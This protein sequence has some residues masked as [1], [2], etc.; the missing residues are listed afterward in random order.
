M[1]NSGALEGGECAVAG[2]GGGGVEGRHSADGGDATGRASRAKEAASVDGDKATTHT[3]D[4]VT[5]NKTQTLMSSSAPAT[6]LSTSPALKQDDT[7]GGS[8]GGSS[9]VVK[10]ST[11]RKL[12]CLYCERSFVSATLRQKHVERVHSV[13]QSRRISSRRQSQLTVTPCVYCDH[14]QPDNT[15]DDLFR[16]LVQEHSNR[17]FG[18]LT[19]KDRFL[20][21]SMLA[22][23]NA[24]IHP[25]SDSP[26]SQPDSQKVQTTTVQE[27]S[28]GSEDP[29]EDPETD[30]EVTVKVTRSRIKKSEENGKK[31]GKLRDLRSR[32]LTVK[33]SRLAL[34]KKEGK[35]MSLKIAETQQRKRSK[36]LDRATSGLKVE[37]NSSTK[38]TDKQTKSGS[39][40]VNPYPEFDSFYR[41]K[42]ITDHSIDN[43]KISSLTFDDVFDKAFFNRIKCNI[44]ENLLH[45]IDGKLFKNQESE[46][47]ISNFEKVSTTP[48]ESQSS[49]QENYGCELSL[50]AVTPVASLSLNSQFGEDFESQI[51]YGAKPSKK[52]TQSK[53]D[54]VHYKYFTRRKFQA[55]ILEQK[56]N[57]DLSKLDMWT[58][59]V[60]K[61][62]QQK[63]VDDK[64]SA[65]EMLE[66]SSCDEYKNK[67]RKEELNKIL[68]RRGPFED[69]KEEASKKA[70][71]DKLNSLNPDRRISP[72][73]FLEVREVLN[74]ILNKVFTLTE[75]DSESEKI[76]EN[77]NKCE[78]VREIPGYLNLRPSSSLPTE[79]DIDHSDK[80]T[81]ICSS[82]E[83]DN[84]EL[85]SN[86][87]RLKDELVELSGE[88][89]RCRMYVCAACGAKLPNMRYLL[90]HKNIYHQNVWVQHY[91]FVGNQSE[92]YRHLSIPAL[93]KVGA[94][95]ERIPCKLWKR[96]DARLCTKCDRQCNSLG[97]L[98]RHVLEC[99]GDWTWMLVRK[100][101]KYKPFGTKSRRKRRGLVQRHRQ[102]T[103]PTERKKYKK[104]FEGPRQKPSDAETIQRMLANLPAKRST[105]KL[106]SFQEGVYKSR[107]NAAASKI[108]LKTINQKKIKCG[109]VIYTTRSIKENM[110]KTVNTQ[111]KPSTSSKT[112][113]SLNKVLS[114]R[115]LDTNAKFSVKR[116]LQALKKQ[117]SARTATATSTER[118]ESSESS[119]LTRSS[120]RSSSKESKQVA[121]TVKKI[122]SSKLNIK[123][124]FPVKK[125]N[126]GKGL[127]ENVSGTDA[128]KKPRGKKT[129]G[130]KS[131]SENK[132]TKTETAKSTAKALDA[133][134]NQS[135]LK[136]TEAKLK[137]LKKPAKPTL[138]NDEADKTA[139]KRK[140]KQ[141]LKNVLNK[142]KKLK[143]DGAASDQNKAQQPNVKD[144][145]LDEGK[146][147]KLQLPDRIVIP[148]TLETKENIADISKNAPV[149][150][151]FNESNENPPIPETMFK[152]QSDNE[153]NLQAKGELNFDRRNVTLETPKT[154]PEMPVEE[155]TVPAEEMKPI[156]IDTTTKSKVTPL[157]S[158]SAKPKTWKPA[159][160]LNDCIAM[161]TSKLQQHTDPK[162]VEPSSVLP[163]VI[164]VFSSSTS[165][166]VLEDPIPHKTE[167][168]LK[169]PTFKTN[170]PFGMEET[171]LD[172]STKKKSEE[173]PSPIWPVSIEQIKLNTV[174]S[175]VDKTIEDVIN[176][177]GLHLS[178]DFGH[179]PSKVQIQFP[180]SSVDDIIDFVVANST[181]ENFKPLEGGI[182]KIR[183]PRKPRDR[184]S[185]SKKTV[186]ICDILK[187]DE[188]DLVVT[189]GIEV[190]EVE[191]VDEVKVGDSIVEDLENILK[192][193]VVTVTSDIL[194]ATTGT[195]GKPDK[196]KEDYINVS[197]SDIMAPAKTKIDTV[198]ENNVVPQAVRFKEISED[199]KLSN[200]AEINLQG[201]KQ[202]VEKIEVKKR[203]RK[204]GQVRKPPVKK[205]EK[206][207]ST[208]CPKKPVKKKVDSITNISIIEEKPEVIETRCEPKK[209][210]VLET[211][212][213]NLLDINEIKN[214]IEV[215]TVQVDPNVNS[216]LKS[217]KIQLHN[218]D[219]P[220]LL[221]NK[222]VT[223]IGKSTSDS[224]DDVPLIALKTVSRSTS[225]ENLT[226][227][228]DKSADSRTDGFE[229]K[230]PPN[231]LADLQKDDVATTEA[232]ESVSSKA[233]DT[234]T[235]IA[236]EKLVNISRSEASDLPEVTAA[237]QCDDKEGKVEPSLSVSKPP[238]E[239][240]SKKLKKAPKGQLR[241]KK[242]LSRSVTNLTT[243]FV[244]SST[245]QIEESEEMAKDDS[246]G[247]LGKQIGE[248]IAVQKQIKRKPL[249]KDQG[250][251]AATTKEATLIVDTVV[252]KEDP[253]KEKVV[254]R[255]VLIKE[256]KL[257]AALSKHKEKTAMELQNF[258]TV[259]P[260]NDQFLSKSKSEPCLFGTLKISPLLDNF[261]PT[262]VHIKSK[263]PEKQSKEDKKLD[264]IDSSE[265][266]LKGD[267]KLIEITENTVGGTILGQNDALKETAKSPGITAIDSVLDETKIAIE[268]SP[269]AGSTTKASK[270]RGKIGNLMRGIKNRISKVVSR[271]KSTNTKQKTLL[272]KDEK[273]DSKEDVGNFLVTDSGALP[274]STNDLNQTPSDGETIKELLDT[275]STEVDDKPKPVRRRIPRS[276]FSMPSEKNS[277]I[278]KSTTDGHDL[279]KIDSSADEFITPLEPA[280]RRSRRPKTPSSTITTERSET[281]LPDSSVAD[282]SKADV[283][284][285]VSG[286]SRDHEEIETLGND[287]R[288]DTI[289]VSDTYK[290]S[291]VILDVK[292][293]STN[294][295]VEKA[296][297]PF[298]APLEPTRRIS[299]NR[300]SKSDASIRSLNTSDVGSS[301]KDDHNAKHLEDIAKP[302]EV[303]QTKLTIKSKL[304]E[305]TILASDLGISGSDA[306]KI[307]DKL[308]FVDP[309]ASVLAKIRKRGSQ[310]KYSNIEGSDADIDSS[311]SD[312]DESI[313]VSNNM[314]IA[315]QDG[316]LAD[317]QPL[318][319]TTELLQ[320]RFPR[321]NSR[322]TKTLKSPKSAA[323]A[324]P[325]VT[326]HL[327]DSPPRKYNDQIADEAA[328]KVPKLK[329]TRLPHLT[330]APVV[331]KDDDKIAA[332]CNVSKRIARKTRILETSEIA[333]ST[334]DSEL[335]STSDT[336][337][338][339]FTDP[340]GPLHNTTP[341]RMARNKRSLKKTYSESNISD[342]CESLD[343]ACITTKD[344]ENIVNEHDDSIKSSQVR[345]PKRSSRRSKLSTAS[346]VDSK[347]SESCES[348][349]DAGD[350]SKTT[351]DDIL[352]SSDSCVSPSQMKL[353]KKSSR[354]TKLSKTSDVESNVSDEFLND[355][356]DVSK[357]TKDDDNISD[358]SIKPLE[359]TLAKRSSRKSE[360]LNTFDIESNIS[361]NCEPSNKDVD[362]NKQDDAISDNVQTSDAS[363]Q[364]PLI[365][366]RKRNIRKSKKMSD[367]KLDLFD[368]IHEDRDIDTTDESNKKT[369]E[370]AIDIQQKAVTKMD[371]RKLRVS[372]TS[373]L[374]PNLPDPVTP[375]SIENHKCEEPLIVRISKIDVEANKATYQADEKN[376]EDHE[377]Y[378]SNSI[379]RGFRPEN[380]NNSN[381]SETIKE[382]FALPL[383]PVQVKVSRR[384]GKIARR[385]K[386]SKIKTPNEAEVIT[387][388]TVSDN[389]DSFS[390]ASEL[391][392]NQSD[393]ESSEEQIFINTVPIQSLKSVSTRTSNSE[394]ATKELNS[395]VCNN[396]VSPDLNESDENS[397]I[398]QAAKTSLKKRGS[399]QSRRSMSLKT[400]GESSAEDPAVNL[401]NDLM[402]NLNYPLIRGKATEPSG[403]DLDTYANTSG[404]I[405]NDMLDVE[406]DLISLKVS[407]KKG[408]KRTSKARMTD[409]SS[410]T[411]KIDVILNPDN[412]GRG[413]DKQDGVNASNLEKEPSPLTPNSEPIQRT[414]PKRRA[415]ALK[416]NKTEIV[417]AISYSDDTEKVNKN[418][419]ADISLNELE[420]NSAVTEISSDTSESFNFNDS[421]VESVRRKLPQRRAKELAPAQVSNASQLS[422]NDELGTDTANTDPNTS[423]TDKSV[424]DTSFNS[425]SSPDEAT[426]ITPT[427][428][429]KRTKISEEEIDTKNLNIVDEQAGLQNNEFQS[430]RETRR[431][432]SSKS[433][434]SLS[435]T[436]LDYNTHFE[437]SASEGCESVDENDKM[438]DTID[439]AVDSDDFLKQGGEAVFDVTGTGSNASE[440]SV[441][442]IRNSEAAVVQRT[443]EQPLKRKS[444][445]SSSRS[446]VSE[447][448]DHSTKSGQKHVPTEDTI[449]VDKTNQRPSEETFVTTENFET[450]KKDSGTSRKSNILSRDL[451]SDNAET[452]AIDSADS[453]KDE[454]IESARP[455]PGEIP[456]VAPVHPVKKSS[457]RGDRVAR[458]VGGKQNLVDSSASED[459]ESAD[460]ISMK[461]EELLTK[462]RSKRT[463]EQAAKNVSMKISESESSEDSRDMFNRN[464]MSDSANS[465]DNCETGESISISESLLRSNSESELFLS[466]FLDQR[467]T[468]KMKKFINGNSITTGE[469][470]DKKEE[471]V[472][473]VKLKK[474]KSCVTAKEDNETVSHSLESSPLEQETP[475]EKAIKGKC[476]GLTEK[477]DTSNFADMIDA[478]NQKHL[479]PSQEEY[480]LAT[481]EVNE[482]E[483]SLLDL[484]I[485]EKDNDLINPSVVLH[486]L[487]EDKLDQLQNSCDTDE[488]AKRVK[489]SDAVEKN[490]VLPR[491][492]GRAK[493]SNKAQGAGISLIIKN[494]EMTDSDNAS[495]KNDINLAHNNLDEVFDQLKVGNDKISQNETS[496]VQ[497]E[498]SEVGST[499]RKNSGLQNDTNEVTEDT[500]TSNL[501][502]TSLGS[503]DSSSKDT[504]EPAMTTSDVLQDDSPSKK[505]LTEKQ[506]EKLNPKPGSNRLRS[507]SAPVK[508]S[509]KSNES[510]FR[511]KSPKKRQ[512]HV[513]EQPIED[514]VTD[515]SGIEKSIDNSITEFDDDIF[516]RPR[517]LRKKPQISYVEP[518][519]MN[520]PRREDSD[521]TSIFDMYDMKRFV[522]ISSDASTKKQVADRKKSLPG[523]KPDFYTNVMTN[524]VAVVFK[525]SEQLDIE[526]LEKYTQPNLKKKSENGEST[527]DVLE[528]TDE[529]SKTSNPLNTSSDYARQDENLPEKELVDFRENQKITKTPT[530]ESIRIII[531]K[532]KTRRKSKSFKKTDLKG[533]NDLFEDFA[534]VI[535]KPKKGVTPIIRFSPADTFLKDTDV[536]D[537]KLPEVETEQSSFDPNNQNL[538]SLDESNQNQTEDAS[539]EE[540]DMELDEIPISSNI[541]ETEK[542][543]D[544]LQ[545][546]GISNGTK[547]MPKK[548]TKGKRSTRSKQKSNTGE[549]FDGGNKINVLENIDDIFFDTGKEIAEMEEPAVFNFETEQI[550]GTDPDGL[551]RL[552]TRTRSNK[553]IDAIVDS[554]I[555]TV[556]TTTDVCNKSEDIDRK[557]G[558]GKANV[559]E[560]VVPLS[561]RSVIDEKL[562]V[563][564]KELDSTIDAVLQ[565]TNVFGNEFENAL[566]ALDKIVPDVPQTD[567]T[568]F[569]S[570]KSNRICGKPIINA[571]DDT[572]LIE[573]EVSEQNN[574]RSNSR[575]R[576]SKKLEE[577]SGIPVTTN[578]LNSNVNET[579][580]DDKEPRRANSSEYENMVDIFENELM[581]GI[582]IEQQREKPKTRSK[583]CSKKSDKEMEATIHN[584]LEATSVFDNELGTLMQDIENQIIPELK[585]ATK[586]DSLT[587]GTLQQRKQKAKGR[588]CTKKSLK[589]TDF[590]LKST[591]DDK[592]ETAPEINPEDADS[593]DDLDDEFIDVMKSESTVSK[594]Q[595]TKELS[596]EVD[597][598]AEDIFKVS[599][600]TK[601]LGSDCVIEAGNDKPELNEKVD[602][603]SSNISDIQT[604]E[605]TAANETV[606]LRANSSLCSTNVSLEVNNIGK[607]TSKGRSRRINKKCEKI[608]EALNTTVKEFI[609]PKAKPKG[610]N[611]ISSTVPTTDLI[612]DVPSEPGNEKIKDIDS[613]YAFNESE[614]FEI[615]KPIELPLRLPRKCNLA[616]VVTENSNI[617]EQNNQK[618]VKEDKGMSNEYKNAY[619]EEIQPIEDVVS[620]EEK[621][622]RAIKLSLLE[623]SA[624]EEAEKINS[625]NEKLELMESTVRNGKIF[626]EEKICEDPEADD[627]STKT[628][629]LAN[630][631]AKE[632]VVQYNTSHVSD[633]A[634]DSILYNI[635]TNKSCSEVEEVRTGNRKTNKRGKKIGSSVQASCIED[636]PLVDLPADDSLKNLDEQLI[637]RDESIFR[638]IDGQNKVD[639]LT[640]RQDSNSIERRSESVQQDFL[641]VNERSYLEGSLVDDISINNI[642]DDFLNKIDTNEDILNEICNEI[643]N[644]ETNNMKTQEISRDTREDIF[645]K[646]DANTD[647]FDIV[648]NYI[649]ESL[650][651]TTK[652]RKIARK[653]R[654]RAKMAENNK[655]KKSVNTGSSIDDVNISGEIKNS[656]S[657]KQSTNMT[658]KDDKKDGS[659]MQ[660]HAQTETNAKEHVIKDDKCSEIASSTL[661][662]DPLEKKDFVNIDNSQAHVFNTNINEEL[663]V[664]QQ[665]LADKG[666]KDVVGDI[667]DT[668]DREK[669]ILE[670]IDREIEENKASKAKKK[671]K[672]STITL[673]ELSYSNLAQL[674]DQHVDTEKIDDVLNQSDKELSENKITDVKSKRVV[675]RKGRKSALSPDETAETNDIDLVI[676]QLNQQ[677]PLE[678]SLDEKELPIT[679][680]TLLEQEIVE[681]EPVEKKVPTKKRLHSEIVGLIEPEIEPVEEGVRKRAVR[682][683]KVKALEHIHDDAL[684]ELTE[685]ERNKQI[686]RKK[687]DEDSTAPV[688]NTKKQTKTK[689]MPVIDPMDFPK[690]ILQEKAPLLA[691]LVADL[692]GLEELRNSI[693]RELSAEN[694]LEGTEEPKQLEEEI[695]ELRRSRRSSR[696]IASYNENEFDPILDALENK[697]NAKKK[698]IVAKENKISNEKDVAKKMNSDELFNLLKASTTEEMYV[699]KPQNSFL[700]N[701]EDTSRDFNDQNFDNVFDNLLEKST[702]LIK[703]S[704]D[705]NIEK[706]DADKIYEFTD[707]P[708]TE[709][710]SISGDCSSKKTKRALQCITPSIKITTDENESMSSELT[711]E[712]KSKAKGNEKNSENYC[713]I[714]N[715]SFVRVESLVKHKRTLTHIQK[716]SEIEAREASEKLKS[717][718][719]QQDTEIN[720]AGEASNVRGD[721]KDKDLERIE[722]PI[723]PVTSSYSDSLK[724]DSSNSNALQTPIIEQNK[725]FVDIIMKSSAEV[726]PKYK[727]YKSLGERKS[728]ESDN[729]VPSDSITE[730]YLIS[731]T[732]IL[733]K[734]ISLLENI[735][736]NQTGGV[737]YAD[738]MSLS[739]NNS[740]RRVTSS[741]DTTKIVDESQTEP[742]K[743]GDDTFLKPAQYEEISEDSANLRSYEEQKLRKTLNRDEELF[744]ECCSLLKSG[745]EVSKSRHVNKQQYAWSKDKGVP[746]KPPF[747]EADESSNGNSRIATPLGSSY[748]DDASGS[749]TISSNWEMRQETAV[750]LERDG[751][752]TR[753]FGFQI[754]EEEREPLNRANEI[755]KPLEVT[756]SENTKPDESIDVK[757]IMTKGARKVFE[758]LKVSIPT[759][760]LN[761]EEVLNTG[762]KSKKG[763]EVE[764]MEESPKKASRKSKPVKKSQ[765]GSNMMFKVNKKKGSPNTNIVIQ[766]E[767]PET[768]YDVYDFEETQDNTEVFTKPD[769]KA[770]KNVKTTDSQETIGEPTEQES[771]TDSRDYL[772]TF[773]VER[774]SSVSSLASSVVKKPKAQENITKK[775]C[776]IMG[777][778]FKNAA[779][780]KVEDIDEDIR[781]IPPIDNDELIENYVASCKRVIRN[782]SKPK[783]S[784]SEINLLF[785][786]LLEDKIEIKEGEEQAEM[787]TAS[788]PAA[789]VAAPPK[790]KQESKEV[791]KKTESKKKHPKI[792]GKKRA[793][794]HSDSTDDEFKITN[795]AKRS[796]KKATKEE[797]NC[798]NLELELKECIGVASRKSQRKCTSGKQNVLVEYWSSD[799]SQ[800][801]AMLESQ[802]IISKTTTD[803]ELAQTVP[804]SH[805]KPVEDKPESI[806]E[807][808]PEEK[809][810][811]EKKVQ[812]KKTV[813][814][815]K[816]KQRPKDATPGDGTMTSDDPLGASAAQ[817]NRRKRAATNPLYHWSSSSEDESQDLIEVKPIRDEPED[818]EDRPIQH[819]WIVGDSPKKLVTMLAQAKGKKTDAD[820]VKEQGKKRTANSAVS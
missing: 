453:R 353:L 102:K 677:K 534:L 469:L 761:M 287:G 512:K 742:K 98:H 495:M 152:L 391:S 438:I 242:A 592:A 633:L 480:C 386:V 61:K 520:T 328:E 539:V 626:N 186:N 464:Y 198:V 621:I 753:N 622:R 420:Q 247:L 168:I 316:S 289:L 51:E 389:S 757:K 348:A 738:D 562:E 396:N 194:P 599:F 549:I 216:S 291:V 79:G 249:K 284:L 584:V 797:D 301:I 174:R 335:Y 618:V 336:N 254:K 195:E 697:N 380:Q 802:K 662:A 460:D 23:H 746:H 359:T 637:S 496:A 210:P 577:V 473:K 234:S 388:S 113:R 717:C 83:T 765:V 5:V 361:D 72:E 32:R 815:K 781:A 707:S 640:G 701:L 777:R 459:N 144:P 181:N 814:G 482:S 702:L 263:S 785:D 122:L 685:S 624:P 153:K 408:L 766:S 395:S 446:K 191:K 47:R 371:G 150:I 812:S 322:K 151:N 398:L 390:D 734:Q 283:N 231:E 415:K 53:K 532:Q 755:F 288:G 76:N 602:I 334:S 209:A 559:A 770:F 628:K 189:K 114:S 213:D 378:K 192:Q 642:D 78:D 11:V 40:C 528:K 544:S 90:D 9:M 281:D 314:N 726:E 134:P 7:S 575:S 698:E 720:D 793:R 763:D 589:R 669:V 132:K 108:P 65:K 303:I 792:K 435:D 800:F 806:V 468:R 256:S 305:Q 590:D 381:S 155:A 514:A 619:A 732:S 409:N 472:E 600:E 479:N 228:T 554:D 778:I 760:E 258:V 354:K 603:T 729:S 796:Y 727:R 440:D 710:L 260:K 2:G 616:P 97:E 367:G 208:K 489:T 462:R 6:P 180:R 759:E 319:S 426:F 449:T 12:L 156:S 529:I 690:D 632:T 19:C 505:K 706:K 35:K 791:N 502:A 226:K 719:S 162:P 173:I 95:E 304:T 100:K 775:K 196:K 310:P 179:H 692:A 751:G 119:R 499:S 644:N 486:Q 533:P 230:L 164:S 14:Q 170:I 306:S 214:N 691:D 270:K 416:T 236:A 111:K 411:E 730:P 202:L 807:K 148:S 392:V 503:G 165:T 320:V 703:A 86:P 16:H 704:A 403:K 421:E 611:K 689:L 394:K 506:S 1:V 451:P 574:L 758:G 492:K 125:Q 265:V 448:P 418:L 794:T 200:D 203:V 713:E 372:K 524:N 540:M 718:E 341:I 443:E 711:A 565:A 109:K 277:D 694:D 545:I 27:E 654:T 430:R 578:E 30:D 44:E 8:S 393:I 124:F 178:W 526:S 75:Q 452:V 780:S 71:L 772:D 782:E 454:I 709:S 530:E 325:D 428:R 120:P 484:D 345:T 635:D 564:E 488:I 498:E 81:L 239:V 204:I 579:K 573:N 233:N 243:E 537:I 185:G 680:G 379:N 49:S 138:N 232:K 387:H 617:V 128:D 70:A 606:S 197:K 282:I 25:S 740:E 425:N 136:K 402:E 385:G 89:A 424:D 743:T 510:R 799:E 515:D 373:V 171:A 246:D 259:P 169:I 516:E 607:Q 73:S 450:P 290:N 94:V 659:I 311:I 658:R 470:Q 497:N 673:P 410:T 563:V 349:I 736:E 546:D 522:S 17:Y 733:E 149:A 297:D 42:K 296:D 466:D 699:P 337:S 3:K 613:I 432:M 183:S 431:S 172:L 427:R 413:N 483:R 803:T 414:T 455:T 279:D 481:K 261:T 245:K 68:D 784:E 553:N 572:N 58:Q 773:T 363:N 774:D 59:L 614:D 326:E 674:K 747:E 60:I 182:K 227:D 605:H 490:K 400:L 56:E 82:R 302:A 351:K 4:T 485:L 657:T 819:G 456:F 276:K 244:E 728:F 591:V 555:H 37:P 368:G 66:Y 776:M 500:N 525:S 527:T 145:F 550:A 580:S 487:I 817:T 43:L 315:V 649:E 762:Q 107:K 54:E 350:L 688:K 91:E 224:E 447:T 695:Q 547:R 804:E 810:P 645:G 566:D 57:R 779:K 300:K 434:K 262:L 175:T 714:C 536:S 641:S 808:E 457:R 22:D 476:D 675:K 376:K 405:E 313:L 811:K 355:A 586:S 317:P 665:L 467:V 332:D 146:Q 333:S 471:S 560:K 267:E 369:V 543:G 813:T 419:E 87:A 671:S 64:K 444:S 407:Q 612:D 631:K 646:T 477:S 708:E 653:R 312:A 764:K 568:K 106:M 429:S 436:S 190:K 478:Q 609:E 647:N 163:N 67:L 292:S 266:N 715:K 55:S 636:K 105:R 745:S 816:K 417:Q 731:K 343:N 338:V 323:D 639:H 404:L 511:S 251:K 587:D 24:A 696:K 93:G 786:Q 268:S 324:V 157:T 309:N 85:P 494:P 681:Q 18:C 382:S 28:K 31:P 521:V 346:D 741:V 133:K 140:L 818:D 756:S 103:E 101:C 752:K 672:R 207:L 201:T 187:K 238:R 159:R 748:D 330:D 582:Q 661:T 593:F 13:K 221:E 318:S 531:N 374:D 184:K 625:S 769:F 212:L 551:I 749:N 126:N 294:S 222:I 50:N 567:G 272:K 33:S 329:E 668:L 223:T 211:H 10:P 406:E 357:A 650:P 676:D 739:S 166:K 275:K 750:D 115:I 257:A 364:L 601:P 684:A 142:V 660:E 307:T 274:D 458:R 666:I 634:D 783:L 585:G 630:R 722:S 754:D 552:E 116:K 29:Q 598:S 161:L 135:S 557:K 110:E 422:S 112:L 20:S 504:D 356:S 39:T 344:S 339:V 347:I 321:R 615:E 667:T 229:D 595:K 561:D 535:K 491:R 683:A 104:R 643:D 63:M 461:N 117:R 679:V 123:S 501:N 820:T 724:L 445:R 137:K 656:K 193:Y 523:K 131:A 507:R 285:D 241:N 34:K 253:Q 648:E 437:F 519:I 252:A 74:E 401:G 670:E 518:D 583:K 88:W 686:G 509:R 652:G 663:N 62:R 77:T 269:V 370:V 365:T 15:L 167:C 790:P 787:E 45:H 154:I 508:K 143:L 809:P 556:K 513:K 121:T 423:N 342:S 768:N 96:S 220:H 581:R 623:Q 80:I 465:L 286:G 240:S 225:Q 118:S 352:E 569:K 725:N 542:L 664:E 604:L 700:N 798:I 147:K 517:N 801:E 278:A 340:I 84:F 712:S 358:I 48:Q 217:D 588:K 205:G 218:E 26:F 219:E 46:T 92:L 474:P 399:K 188:K 795:T 384:K 788:K 538:R 21:L 723:E 366:F 433:L 199:I 475:T 678:T 620:L 41:V 651:S 771:D 298:V 610:I 597:Q 273:R 139:K 36:Q 442:K 412:H 541:I 638:N 215:S 158:P 206:A 383:E 548:K 127:T 629:K 693:E 375:N 176:N 377:S 362:I 576:R 627:V 594:V 237:K 38:I 767:E 687:T 721:E 655:H 331:T 255:G 248:K 571:P 439:S 280:R 737:S 558:K 99:G 235:D 570:R 129:E 293:Q 295:D 52:K 735:I 271:Q 69:L 716:L 141:N 250:K 397:H 177:A 299:R 327:N 463:K 682:S 493:A 596:R 264:S 130:S 705:R 805:E 360:L 160:G 441:S 608:T 789:V 308:S 744:L